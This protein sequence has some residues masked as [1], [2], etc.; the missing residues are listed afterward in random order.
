MVFFWI[1]VFVVALIVLVKGADW[2]IESS[3][4]IGLA[5]GLSPFIVGVT[6]VGIGTSFPEL[7]SSI[8]AIFQGVPEVVVANAVGSNIANI[9]LVI[10]ASAVIGRQLLVSKDLIDLDLPLLACTTVL[11]LGVLWDAQITV[12][13]SILMLFTY[14]G[15]FLYTLFSK[16]KDDEN[17][18]KIKKPKLV[19]K[20]FI[21][22]VLGIV[23]L[24]VGAK[25]LIDALVELSTLLNIATGVIA[26]T[27]V[28]IGTSLPELLVSA[29][30][31]LRGK[32]EVALGN[33]FGSNVFN[34]L[35]VVGLPGLFTTLPVDEKTF[36]IGVPTMAIATLLFVISGISKK[37]YIWE[38]FFFLSIYV[39]FIAK[40][41]QWF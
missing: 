1:I 37:I 41:F 21:F 14:G 13:E 22:L 11:F 32:S 35:V 6:I 38:G 5:F 24:V 12:G 2:L 3:E 4:K 20:D 15:Y 26:I 25:Y 28:A 27:A 16:N 34:A 19:L 23:G 17:E 8:V 18:K 36:L 29:K 9:L 39:L 40:L 30:A 7:I 31:A 33:I 10:G